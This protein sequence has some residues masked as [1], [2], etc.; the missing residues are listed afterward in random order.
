[1]SDALW[2]KSAVETAA[3]IREKQFSCTEVMAAVVERIRALNPKL[4]AIVVDFTEQALAEAAKAD[5]A[6]Q[7]APSR[8]RCSAFR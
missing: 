6:L 7:T 5:R 1:M 4:N 8:D 3:G 2:Q